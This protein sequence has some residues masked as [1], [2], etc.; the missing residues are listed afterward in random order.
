MPKVR[1]WIRFRIAVP[2]CHRYTARGSGWFLVVRQSYACLILA[3]PL[4]YA[5]G[6]ITY[7]SPTVPTTMLHT[8]SSCVPTTTLH[9]NRHV[10]TTTLHTNR[11][12]CPRR[13]CI[14][15]AMRAHD[16]IAYLKSPCV[17]TTTLHTQNRR[18]CPRRH[19]IQIAVCAHNDIAYKSPCVPTTTL[20][21]KSP[22]RPPAFVAPRVSKGTYREFKYAIRLAISVC[23]SRGQGIC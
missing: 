14:Q 18:V 15:I 5:R 8:I 7:R 19:C 3:S 1:Q 16:D 10:P 4:A 6:Y 21:T 23:E 17:P 9:T 11:H 2:I 13:H 12:V 22:G 20:H